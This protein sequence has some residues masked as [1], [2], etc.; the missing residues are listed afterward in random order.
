[1]KKIVS[2][3]VLTA[4]VFLLVGCSTEKEQKREASIHSLPLKKRRSLRLFALRL[5]KRMN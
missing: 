1:M 3:A 5:L 4:S 2:F